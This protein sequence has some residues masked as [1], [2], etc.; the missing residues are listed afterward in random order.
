MKN[1]ATKEQ[2]K[3]FAKNIIKYIDGEDIVQTAEK[4]QFAEQSD[5]EQI[6]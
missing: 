5:K 3:L 1:S 4:E 2:L 6:G